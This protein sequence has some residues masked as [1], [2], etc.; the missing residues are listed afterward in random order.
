[1]KKYLFLIAL[2]AVALSVSAQKAEK[3]NKVIR[4]IAEYEAFVNEVVMMPFA[5]FHGD[6]LDNVEKQQHKFVR[7]YRWH[8]QDKMSIDQL[9]QFNK[10]RGKYQR[11]MT[12]LN[13]RRRLA[14]TRGRIHGYFERLEVPDTASKNI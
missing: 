14:A 11:K 2:M 13:N 5:D 12:A 10:L 4:F 1:M 6:T 3:P 9:E 8:Y 7:R